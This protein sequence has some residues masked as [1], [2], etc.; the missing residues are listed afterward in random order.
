M[1]KIKIGTSSCLLGENV[2]WNAGHCFTKFI[3]NLKDDYQFI[4]VCPEIGIG[5][6][7][8]RPTIRLVEDIED[9]GKTS[10]VSTKSGKDYTNT[11]EEFSINKIK[12][13][14]EIGINGFL[15]KSKSPTCGLRVKVYKK[16]DSK[17]A[18]NIN[19]KGKFAEMLER[20]WPELPITEEGRLNNTILYEKFTISTEC[21]KDWND[22]VDK[23]DVNTLIDFHTRHKYLLESLSQEKKRELGRM[24]ANQKEIEKVNDV[25]DLYYNKFFL[26]LK[27]TEFTP[28]KLCHIYGKMFD[29]LMKDF[30][31]ISKEDRKEFY[32]YLGLVKT[33]KMEKVIPKVLLKHYVRKSCNKYLEKQK[34]LLSQSNMNII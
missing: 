29:R 5:L 3:D 10:L 4:S 18:T 21:H 11:M 16:F 2:R 9:I 13:L 14:K 8:P 6:G 32:T 20:L 26:T 17:G 22:N 23:E 27:N 33:G 30:D 28:E 25:Y 7:I 31:H 15:L 12:E 24:V 1:S 34:I 19:S